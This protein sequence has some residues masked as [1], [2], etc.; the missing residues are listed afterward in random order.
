VWLHDLVEVRESPIENRGLFATDDLSEGIVV[1]RL[2]GRLVS[3]AELAALLDQ[4]TS[5]LA[6]NPY[7]DTITVYEDAHLVEEV[8]VP[9]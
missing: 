4:A 5:G 9:R 8:G 2:G 6:R 3:T 7:I 1:I